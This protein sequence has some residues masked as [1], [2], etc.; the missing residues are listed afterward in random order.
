ML[1]LGGIAPAK[2]A[3][4]YFYEGSPYS[5]CQVDLPELPKSLDEIFGKDQQ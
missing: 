2:R 3:A 4:K 5:L 1:S